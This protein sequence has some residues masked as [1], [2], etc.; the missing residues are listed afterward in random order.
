MSTPSSTTPTTSVSSFRER[1]LSIL[2]VIAFIGALPVAGINAY[3]AAQHGAY[4]EAVAYVLA[5]VLLAVLIA[6]NRVPQTYAIRTW[7]L[8]FILYAATTAAYL[9][10]GLSGDGRVWL[11][12]TIAIGALL[13]PSPHNF[14]NF[15]IAILYHFGTGYAFS[16]HL[17]PPPPSEHL[18][19]T[20]AFS[21]WTRTGV[22]LLGLAAVV[23]TAIS[24]YRSNLENTLEE[25][26]T[27][28][29]I[30]EEERQ[31]LE[32]QGN[33]LHRR[34][35]Q[36]RIA[37]EIARIVNTILDPD[38]L[39]EQVVN[40]VR[41]HFDLYYVGIFLVDE[42]GEYA[43]LKAGTGDAGRKMFMEGHRLAI[44]GASMIGWS[45][46]NRQPRIALDVG[47]D[48]VRFANPHLPLTRTE[49]ALP[50]I[51]RG[52][53][54]GAMTVQS[55]QPVAFDEDDLTVLQSIVDNVATALH[56]ARLYQESQHGLQILA[57]TQRRRF[58]T[59][60]EHLLPPHVEMEVGEASDDETDHQM[61]VPIMLY[62]QS[63][64]EIILEGTQPWTDE[65]RA[66][67]RQAS[68]QLA[69]AIEN[70]Y[71]TQETQRTI[72]ENRLLAQITDQVGATLDIDTVIQT[73]LSELR[74][75]LHVTEAEIQFVTTEPT[76]TE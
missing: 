6:L 76:A 34:L 15:L 58:S 25:S 33:L 42:R 40:L 1:L 75:V 23:L 49:L 60:W 68:A 18:V 48:A 2:L 4:V 11:F 39:I 31:R 30:L 53:V 66:F 61:R 28:N 72:Q 20:L 27:L 7:G 45:I 65:E 50:L 73:A 63:L 62:G 29:T 55:E 8:I 10:T 57:E 46:S 35:E 54:L 56:N 36:I 51:S 24:L 13:L 12:G 69:L 47:E 52:E 9:T 64:G 14:I 21:A 71:L 19:T 32:Q 5:I 59:A 38:E 22:L 70:I 16:Q 17:L 26:Q 37:G 43:V 74:H 67:A 3:Y 41:D 44:G